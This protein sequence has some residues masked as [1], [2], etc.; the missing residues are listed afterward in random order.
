MN[1]RTRMTNIIINNE[2]L[3]TSLVGVLIVLVHPKVVQRS[4]LPL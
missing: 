3:V 4:M 1:N 2:V